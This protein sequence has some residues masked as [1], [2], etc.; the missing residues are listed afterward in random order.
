MLNLL[1]TQDTPSH[2]RGMRIRLRSFFAGEGWGE[3]FTDHFQN[4]RCILHHKHCSASVLSARS[5][6][7]RC[8][9]RDLS[10]P[11]PQPSPTKNIGVLIHA[12]CVGEGVSVP[13]FRSAPN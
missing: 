11:S 9:K 1:I 3:G 6:R 8:L 4:I 2:A 10:M 5:F 13:F 12:S 7:A